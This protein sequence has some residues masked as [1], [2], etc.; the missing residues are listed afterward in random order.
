LRWKLLVI[1][2]LLAAFA[3]AG[4][5]V[6]SIH[7]VFASVN[8]PRPGA[9]I[10]GASFLLPV[11]LIVYAGIFVYRHTARR[12]K[13]QA[14]LTVL[15]SLLLF[16]ASCYAIGVITNRLWPQPTRIY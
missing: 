2:S 11:A 3:G 6:A 8:F 14:V 9:Y 1:A 12:R 16:A 13:L 10:I 15:L 4:L 5:V 7:V